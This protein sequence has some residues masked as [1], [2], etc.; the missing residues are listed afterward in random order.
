M[1]NELSTMATLADKYFGLFLDYLPNII[2]AIILFLLGLWIIKLLIKYLRRLFEKRK[3]DEALR[4]FLLSI[5]DIGLKIILTIIV[6]AKLGVETSSLVAMLGAAGL[7]VGLALQGSLANFAG[8]V[9]IIVLRPFKI[10]DWIDA[11]GESGTVKEITVF[12]TKLINFNQVLVVIPNGRLS[13]NKITNYTVEG[14]RKDAMT[15]RVAYGT[16]IAKAREVLLDLLTEQKG[17]YTDPAP[18][19]VVGELTH[20]CVNLSVRFVSSTADFWDIHWHTLEHAE[21]RLNAVGIQM[22][23]P[24]Y[25]VELLNKAQ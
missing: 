14:R 10:G 8:G 9:M 2:G 4:H 1:M 24:K 17:V 7:A 16:N 22:P 3:Y 5:I 15:I 12:Y 13:N 25:D 20:D 18:Q 11:D 19:V 23:Y 6:I 21:E